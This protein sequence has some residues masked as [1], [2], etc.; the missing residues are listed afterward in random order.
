MELVDVRDS[1]SLVLTDVPVRLRPPL[2]F[3]LLAR[4]LILSPK[5]QLVTHRQGCVYVFGISVRLCERPVYF[6]WQLC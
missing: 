5:V 2:P 6:A 4:F 3:V 1:K